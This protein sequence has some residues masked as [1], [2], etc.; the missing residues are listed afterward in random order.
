ME[1]E[2]LIPPPEDRSEAMVEASPFSPL[3]DQLGDGDPKVRET[4]IWALGQLRYG[5]AV[6]RFSRILAKDEDALVRCAS[7]RG[8]AVIGGVAAAQALIR[9]LKDPDELVR[10][11]CVIG[12]GTLGDPQGLYPLEAMLQREQATRGELEGRVRWAVEKLQ[13]ANDP[14]DRPDRRRGGVSKKISKYLEQVHASPRDGI[15]HNNLAVAY[16]HAAEYDLAVRHCLLAKGLGARVTWLEEELA[17][18][19]H[20]SR[21]ARLSPEDEAFLKAPDPVQVGLPGVRLEPEPRRI[22]AR[23]GRTRSDGSEPDTVPRGGDPASTP[24]GDEPSIDLPAPP[25]AAPDS[26]PSASIAPAPASAPP[27]PVA[28]P[29]ASDVAAAPVPAL[30]TPP[31]DPIPSSVPTPPASGSSLQGPVP[32]P[33]P[34]AEPVPIGLADAAPDDDLPSRPLNRSERRRLEKL[35]KRFRRRREG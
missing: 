27:V 17:R 4:A 21:A 33:A 16:F 2:S 8:L 29:P 18:V 23:V 34:E 20:D 10:E 28:S 9:G 5:P 31:A 19:G 13:R 30:P 3:L 22:D 26:V 6:K 25:T 1:S 24:V 7:A 11:V 35:E 14:G 15:G 12:L 32:D